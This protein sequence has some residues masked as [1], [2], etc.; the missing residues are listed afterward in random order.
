MAKQPKV[1]DRPI[2][3]WRVYA[4]Y[5]IEVPN[6]KGK[7]AWK[8]KKQL[9][10]GI[11]G[12]KS[13]ADQFEQMYR[14][15]GPKVITDKKFQRECQVVDVRVMAVQKDDGLKHPHDSYSSF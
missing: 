8:K 4:F 14:V 2:V 10:S 6:T 15:L 11:F 1:D 7:L 9:V 12:I 13:A 3:K 5:M